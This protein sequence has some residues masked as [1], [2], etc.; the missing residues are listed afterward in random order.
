MR[1]Q[2]QNRII[3]DGRTWELISGPWTVAE[4]WLMAKHVDDFKKSGID[5][6]TENAGDD[7][8]YV[9]RC[10]RGYIH[11]KPLSDNPRALIARE[12]RIKHIERER[13]QTRMAM[14][15]YRNKR[16]ETNQPVCLK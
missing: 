13:E 7:C 4:A 14:R 5:C 3:K 2:I 15:R 8:V 1:T 11:L 9:Y 6:I 10:A 12:R 16:Y